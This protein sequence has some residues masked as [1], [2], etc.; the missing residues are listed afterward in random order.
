MNATI[1]TLTLF[2]S[3]HILGA[4]ASTIACTAT[5]DVTYAAWVS[6]PSDPVQIPCLL[7][8]P[9][10]ADPI[11]QSNIH[12]SLSSWLATLESHLKTSSGDDGD[13]L[14]P[15]TNSEAHK[16]IAEHSLF[17]A[18]SSSSSS[19]SLAV[20]SP[21]PDN[22]RHLRGRNQRMTPRCVPVHQPL[23]RFV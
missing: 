4:L 6:T 15:V 2:H 12:S 1:A 11:V 8:P 16:A 19:S 10:V 14:R 20:I 7:C 17:Y 21:Q 9:D 13:C 23:P 5:K 3:L 18:P 22:S